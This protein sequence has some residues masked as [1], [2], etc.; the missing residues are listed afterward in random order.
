MKQIY[1]QRTAR[2]IRAIFLE[3]INCF[4]EV[5]IHDSDEGSSSVCALLM[6]VG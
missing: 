6:E 3:D 2:D 1:N 5:L 4:L